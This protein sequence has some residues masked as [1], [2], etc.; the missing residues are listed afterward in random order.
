MNL[1]L[2]R[3]PHAGGSKAIVFQHYASALL[4]P[5]RQEEVGEIDAGQYNPFVSRV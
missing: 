3:A 2:I 5:L 4:G 1:K